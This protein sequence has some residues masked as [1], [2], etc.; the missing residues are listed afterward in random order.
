[1]FANSASRACAYA[2]VIVPGVAYVGVDLDANPLVNKLV[3]ILN[4]VLILEFVPL[5]FNTGYVL[6]I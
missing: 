2:L 3:A 6:S 4:N 1:M 5:L